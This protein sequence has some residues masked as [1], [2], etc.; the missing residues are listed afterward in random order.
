MPS[1][2]DLPLPVPPPPPETRDDSPAFAP[3]TTLVARVTQDHGGQRYTLRIGSLSMSV[4][5]ERP[6]AMG[7]EVR[8]SV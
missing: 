4:E 1:V 2:S 8:L 7:Q 6:L 5:S 3:G